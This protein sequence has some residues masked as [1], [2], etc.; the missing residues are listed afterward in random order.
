MVVNS[1]AR[2]MGTEWGYQ[3][4]VKAIFKE[5]SERV[6]GYAGLSH[7]RLAAEG[8]IATKP[9][10]V[11]TGGIDQ[12]ELTSRLAREI[13]SV[14][15]NIPIDQALLETKAGSRLHV[16]I[17]RSRGLDNLPPGPA[18]SEEERSAP[19]MFPA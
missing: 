11:D 7:N 13:D 9:K 17:R 12:S 6:D 8:A 19:L 18:E 5:I 2:L 3:G 16:A 14:D 10:P 4:S 15:T 1:L